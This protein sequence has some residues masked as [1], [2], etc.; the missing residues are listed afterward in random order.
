M[1]LSKIP[2]VTVI[3][4]T[5]AVQAQAYSRTCPAP[6][7][8]GAPSTGAGSG[9]NGSTIVSTTVTV[10][11]S[12]SGY[13]YPPTVQYEVC[14]VYANGSTKCYLASQLPGGVGGVGG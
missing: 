14:N 7:P 2:V 4:G 3:P 13:G 6:L 10:V 1:S 11:Q 9:V 12:S 5:P 8:R